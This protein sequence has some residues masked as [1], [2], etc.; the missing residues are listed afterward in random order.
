MKNIITNLKTKVLLDQL[1]TAKDPLEVYSIIEE[2]LEGDIS[3]SSK[4][5]YKGCYIHYS[6]EHIKTNEIDDSYIWLN[7][8][9]ESNSETVLNIHTNLTKANITNVYNMVMSFASKI[10]D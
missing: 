9:I 1:K 6:F 3:T 8:I 4:L 7:L 10:W 2:Y 5:K